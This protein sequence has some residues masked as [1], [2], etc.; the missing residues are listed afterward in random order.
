MFTFKSKIKTHKKKYSLSRVESKRKNL[1]ES[2]RPRT[3]SDKNKFYFIA[4]VKTPFC[5]FFFREFTSGRL[6][7][8]Y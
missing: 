6:K 4:V 5:Q 1:M 2:G 8:D 7:T 3:R